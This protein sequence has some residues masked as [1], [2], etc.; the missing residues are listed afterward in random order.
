MKNRKKEIMKKVGKTLQEIDEILNNVEN[1]KIGRSKK[2]KMQHL[3]LEVFSM[4]VKLKKKFNIIKYI[5][6]IEQKVAKM[7][8]ANIKENNILIY[9]LEYKIFTLKEMLLRL[10]QHLQ[11]KEGR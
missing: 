10:Y 9:I 7:E 5:I 11:D 1:I 4:S 8:T 3:L 6:A 2:I